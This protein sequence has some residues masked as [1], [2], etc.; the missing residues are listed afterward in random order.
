M[1]V[2][3]VKLRFQDSETWQLAVKI[4][5]ELLETGDELGKK[6]LQNSLVIQ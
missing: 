5:D 2:S 6:H 4:D 1:D 3:M